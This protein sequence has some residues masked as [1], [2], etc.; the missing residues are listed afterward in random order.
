MPSEMDRTEYAATYGP[1]TGDRIR[2]G[3]T[4]LVVEVERDE[5]GYGDEL[6]AGCG[7]TTQAGIGAQGRG[8]GPSSLDLLVTGVVVIDPVLG[9]VK[10]NIGIKDGR[11]VG[12]GRAGNPDVMDNIDLIVGPH[13]GFI[14]GG[15][16]IATP[17]GVDS[18]VHLSAPD[19]VPVL[20]GSGI[21]TIV[22]MGSGGVWDIG[23]N[24]RQN[25]ENLIAAWAE[26]PMNA[27]F[28]ARATTDTAALEASLAAGVSGFKIHED[29]GG[30]Q[31]VIDRTLD[32]A[33]GFDVAVAM[34][35]D[36][37]N[38][39]GILA[40]TM[41]TIAGRTVHAYHVEGSGGGHVPNTLEMLSHPNVLASSTTPT[42]PL[43]VHTA[44]EMV[45]MAMIVHHQDPT[46]ETDV[47]A[48]RSRV[49]VRTMEAESHLQDLGAI[50]IINSDSLGMG[51]GGE[52]IRRTW[53]LAH[54]MAA[55]SE[56]P[57][58]HNDRVRRY[59]AKYTINPA[60]THGL[61]RHVGSLEPGKLA[62]IVLWRPESFGAKPETVIKAGFVT[63][64]APGDGAGSIRSSLPRRYGPMFGALGD[65]ARRLATIFVAET[66]DGIRREFRDR[67]FATV[68]GTRG[69]TRADLIHNTAVPNV[70]VP[71]S[72]SPVMID[73][74]P[75]TLEPVTEIP[76]GQR[77]FFA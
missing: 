5:A 62:D 63:W 53:Q 71:T 19:V 75:A 56:D 31:A 15:G 61:S 40:D 17:G 20:L 24:P 66:G 51:R 68:S 23:V 42:V 52:V 27:S 32:V 67:E 35:T 25:L 48:T 12:V 1:T 21:T 69:L 50:G 22:G 29:W 11:I 54:V 30:S 58:P 74:Q 77:Y 7:K 4:S 47:A 55:A 37:L 26:F 16:M 59:L 57:G 18:H 73:G 28:L 43:G 36:S 14:S 10:A 34:H 8:H 44:E 33:E 70:A 9:I 2:L 49:R 45:P 64:A 46:I 41:A 65:A 13:T 76:L 60:I 6:L 72:S 39:A 38:E 3:D